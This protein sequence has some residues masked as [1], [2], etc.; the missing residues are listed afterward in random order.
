MLSF[1]IWCLKGHSPLF[2]NV[3]AIQ[4][5]AIVPKYFAWIWG[6]Q[7]KWL[8]ICV[9]VFMK[10]PFEVTRAFPKFNGIFMIFVKE[11]MQFVK[12]GCWVSLVR[13]QFIVKYSP[14]GM[15]GISDY[16]NF[17]HVF[18]DVGLI[19]AASDSKQFCFHVCYECCMMNHFDKRLIGWVYM[20]NRCSDV[21]FDAS[22]CYDEG[23]EW[24]GR[25]LK[26][27]FTKFLN[28]SFVFFFFIN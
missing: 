6:S 20:R 7:I 14:S 16:D 2:N 26:N 27:Y 24:R 15:N 4:F 17:W 23:S 21:I 5:L 11:M 10:S 9:D 8:G 28:M 19:D 13:M 22:I 1:S 25:D 18:F 3:I 12:N